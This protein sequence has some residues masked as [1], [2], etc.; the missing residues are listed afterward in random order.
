MNIN[1]G[2]SIKP[3]WRSRSKRIQMIFWCKISIN[4][5]K[6]CLLKLELDLEGRSLFL[7]IWHLKNWQSRRRW[8]ECDFGGKYWRERK[9]ILLLRVLP[10][11]V[12]LE[13]LSWI[14]KNLKKVL[15]TTVIGWLRIYVFYYWFSERIMVWTSIGVS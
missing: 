5:L 1:N 15:I 11:K 10:N 2:C 4:K 6:N 9:T 8:R 3:S 7:F 14:L 12:V 13:M